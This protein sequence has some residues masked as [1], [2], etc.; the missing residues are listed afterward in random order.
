[1]NNERII[2]ISVI[3]IIV[4]LVVINKYVEYISFTNVICIVSI[5]IATT[6]F[7]Y[8]SRIRKVREKYKY[9]NQMIITQNSIFYAKYDYYKQHNI[10]IPEEKLKDLR[11]QY[12]FNRRMVNGYYKNVK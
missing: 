12:E 11:E 9:E 7:Y 1:M 8:E 5:F 6:A 4:L 10:D 3:A 2:Q